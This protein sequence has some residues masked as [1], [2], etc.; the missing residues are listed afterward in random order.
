MKVIILSE[1]EFKNLMTINSID[2]ANVASQNFSVISIT[3]SGADEIHHFSQDHQNVLNLEFDDVSKEEAEGIVLFGENR[4]PIIV[5]DEEH[6][7]KIFDFLEKNN[8]TEQLLVHCAAGISR[9]GAVGT[10][11]SD[12]MDL[13]NDTKSYEGF[14]RLNRHIQPNA[15]IL[16]VMHGFMYKNCY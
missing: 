9:S 16:R 12:Y 1:R 3:G 2:D 7:K 6:A 13:L 14:N 8:K 4:N 10:V 11:A 15:F 5:F